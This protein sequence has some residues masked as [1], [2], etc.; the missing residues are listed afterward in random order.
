[1]TSEQI[2]KLR[3]QLCYYAELFIGT[4]YIWGGDDPLG[5]DCSGHAIFC[6][7]K[8]ELLPKPFDTTAQG[9]FDR[10]KRWGV[11]TAEAGCLAFWANGEGRI[12]HVAICLDDELCITADHGDSTTK[13]Y[14]DAIAK[15][16]FVRVREIEHR[17]TPAILVDP[18]KQL[19]V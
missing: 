10:Y 1:M 17:K 9:L 3:D 12:Y 18:F 14:A 16:A 4:P 15:N 6:L 11:K 7:Q 19:E 13:T 5:F 2:D 8:V